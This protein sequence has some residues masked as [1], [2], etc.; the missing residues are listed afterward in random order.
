MLTATLRGTQINS[1]TAI[2]DDNYHMIKKA[3][4]KIKC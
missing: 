2:N 3:V 4:T 1:N